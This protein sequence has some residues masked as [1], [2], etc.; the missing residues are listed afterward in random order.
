MPKP[1]DT[2]KTR[3]E[4]T[5]E[6]EY[7]SA[8]KDINSN[9]KLMGSEMKLAAAQFADNAKSVDALKARQEILNQTYEEQVQK[10]KAAEQWT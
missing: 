7:K 8:I 9:I 4:I 6:K 5:G 1:E 3:I 2:I 10:V